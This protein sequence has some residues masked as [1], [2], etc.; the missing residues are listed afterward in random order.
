MK[1]QIF[2]HLQRWK[3]DKSRKPLILMG[4]RQVGKTYLLKAFGTQ[5]YENIA[6]CNF[7]NS[8]SLQELFSR[9]LKPED[10]LKILSIEL[11]IE[12]KP[13]TTLIIFDE[14]Q[15]CP[16]ALNSLKYFNEFANEYHICAAGSLLGVTLAGNQGFPVGKVNFMHLYPLSFEEFLQAK[17]ERKLMQYLDDINKIES[18][19]LILHEKL[20]DFFKEYLYVGGMPA[21]V[22][23][24]IDSRN[25]NQIRTMQIHILE[26]YRLDF[27]KHASA[28]IIMKLN[29]VWNVIPSQLAKENKKFIYSVIRTGA[30]AQE[31]EN[32]IQWLLEAGLIHKVYTTTIPKLPL[33]AYVH[34]DI[35]KIYLSDVGLL[36]AMA[37]LSEKTIIHGNEIYQEFRGA[38]I[39]NYVAQELARQGYGLFY[40]ASQGQ[41]ELDFLLQ[42]NDAIYPIEVKSGN[43]HRKKSLQIYIQKYQPNLAIRLSP[44]NLKLDGL[45]LNCPLYFLSKLKKLIL[46]TRAVQQ[47][48]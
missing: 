34:H 44:M 16:K 18:L 33:S 47:N 3:T 42:D 37:G 28:N 1:R 19:P 35:F 43:T 41:A 5:E 38:L 20:S 27:A 45:I 17:G 31:F 32:A 24:Y 7:E 11:S 48:L 21:A 10:I 4:A 40:W 9:S 22:S 23:E 26:A 2:N 29:Q 14:I 15:E 25:F 39:E 13:K 6:Y 30:R 8:P 46:Q 36:G 12:I